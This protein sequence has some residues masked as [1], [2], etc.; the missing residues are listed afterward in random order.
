MRKCD[1]SATVFPDS[2]SQTLQPVVTGDESDTFPTPTLDCFPA[3]YK[4]FETV[5]QAEPHGDLNVA[6]L[7]LSVAFVYLEF[8]LCIS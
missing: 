6:A 3:D 2:T 1:S 8:S 4:V 7:P 5:F